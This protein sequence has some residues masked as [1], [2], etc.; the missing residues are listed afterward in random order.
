MARLQH[1][2]SL[3]VFD[4]TGRAIISLQSGVVFLLS[5]AGPHRLVVAE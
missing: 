2:P 5:P 1:D 4:A 3:S